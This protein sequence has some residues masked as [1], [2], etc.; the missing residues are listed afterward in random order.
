MLAATAAALFTVAC[1]KPDNTNG[2]GTGEVVPGL[3][4]AVYRGEKPTGK[5][6]I[7]LYSIELADKNNA[8]TTLRIDLRSDVA[9]SDNIAPAAGTYELGTIEDPQLNTFIVATT[10]TDD[11]GSIYY[12]NGTPVLLKEGTVNIRKGTGIQQVIANFT[13]ETGETIEWEFKGSITYLDER[14]DLPRQEIT[15]DYWDISY[16]GEYP[17]ADNMGLIY[18]SVAPTDLS[19]VLTLAITTPLPADPNKVAV[20][21]GTFAVA[22]R[23]SEANKLIEGSIEGQNILHSREITYNTST[24]MMNGGTL[25]TDGTATITKNSD[26]TYTL[27][28]E[29]SGRSFNASGTLLGNVDNIKYTLSNVELP[30][31]IDNASQ[32]MSTLESDVEITE[33]MEHF[34]VDPLKDA[35]VVPTNTTNLV[36]WRFIFSDG[37]E[38]I[39][40]ND[41]YDDYGTLYIRGTEGKALSIQMI[42]EAPSDLNKITIPTGDFPMN[43]KYL[44]IS[45]GIDPN[46]LEA[47]TTVSGNPSMTDPFALCIG[48]FYYVIGQVENSDGTKVTSVIDGG[49]AVINKGQ[50]TITATGEDTYEVTF[51]FFDKFD[52][53]ISGKQTFTMSSEAA[54][55]AVVKGTLTQ[56][57]YLYNPT[58]EA[59]SN[60]PFASV[61]SV[62][63]LK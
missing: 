34:Y 27:T 24:Q 55:Q 25:I 35:W 18:F 43:D 16:A 63:S 58:L 48:T 31:Y 4:Q 51:E 30:E 40:D 41:D 12:N 32:P 20:P 46:E 53:K 10:A 19:S 62:V 28:T 38:M 29:L 59:F 15:A 60:S 17:Y 21:E 42:T 13:T 52:H 49:G 47:G 54:T 57:G 11:Y 5:A 33:Q 61:P 45:L 6:G 37:V 26:G 14:E 23:P 22:T 56:A 50:T 3:K 36:I 8:A 7:A 44:D 9:T 2:G 39:N 1:Q